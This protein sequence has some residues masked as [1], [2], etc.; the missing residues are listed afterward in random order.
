MSK[1]T[2]EAKG[3]LGPKVVPDW[4]VI[5]NDTYHGCVG[6]NFT[7]LQLWHLILPYE[8]AHHNNREQKE[9]NQAQCS[10]FHLHLADWLF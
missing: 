9:D 4:E 2:K 5:P 3:G 7:C 8:A 10:P 6:V 1:Y